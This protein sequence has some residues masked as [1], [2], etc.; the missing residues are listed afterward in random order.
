MSVTDQF[1]QPSKVVRLSIATTTPR[2]SSRGLNRPKSQTGLAPKRSAGKSSF[3][4]GAQLT[5]TVQVLSQDTCAERLLVLRTFLADLVAALSQIDFPG[6]NLPRARNS[7]VNGASGW[8]CQTAAAEHRASF[9]GLVWNCRRDGTT[10]ML[11][12]LLKPQPS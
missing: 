8:R 4:P 1:A 12:R 2:Y 7:L 6:V 10:P 3:V 11:S 9:M 5:V